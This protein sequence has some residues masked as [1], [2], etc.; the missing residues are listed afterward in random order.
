MQRRSRVRVT[1]IRSILL[2]MA[3][4]LGVLGGLFVTYLR[5]LPTLEALEEY[6]PSLVTTLY[7]DH[8]EPFATLFEQKR[9]WIPLDTIPRHLINGVIAVEDAQFYQHRGINFRGIA[10]ALL[11]NLRALRPAEGGSSITQQ[12]AKLLLLTPEKHLSRKIKEAVLAIE[13]EKRYSKEKILELYLNQVYFGHGAYGVESAAHTY[14]K[15]PV[16]QLNLAEAA[17]L[18]GLPRAPN[19]Y[20]PIADKE[21][22]IRRRNHV[23]TRM[24]EEGFI[25]KQQAASALAVTFNEFPFEKTRNLGPYFVEYIRQ[26]LEERYGTYAVYHGGLKVYTTL[27]VGAQRSAETAL[28][29]GLREIDKARGFRAPR[30]RSSSAAVTRKGALSYLIPKAGE[31]LSATVTKILPKAVTVQV[32]G[33]QGDIALDKVPWLDSSQPRQQLQPGM[34]LKVQVLR[35]NTRT[36]MLDLSLEQDPEI[37]GA[38]LAIDPGDG[39][40]KAMIGGYDF[41][42]SKFNRAV[43]ARRQPGSAFKPFVYAAAF[44]RGLTPSTI[45][46]DAPVS[47]PILADGKR[48]E[49]SPDNYDRKFRGPTTLRYGLEHSINVVAVKLIE[50]IGVDSVIELARNL[51]IESTLRREYA[52]ALGVSEVTLSELVSAFGVFAHS[53]IRFLPYGIRKVTDNKGA[54]LEEYI[55]VGQQT[56][57]E[58]TAFT[59]TSVL[60]GV[61]ERGTG[62][63][64]RV[65]GR[66]VAGK[67]GTTQAATDAWFIGYTPHLVAGVWVGY[68]TKRSLGPH[69]SAATLA[70]PIWTRF[71]QRAV[72]DTPTEEFPVPANAAPALVN[73]VSGRPT[74]SDDKDAIK[75]FVF[76]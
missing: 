42:R 58:E 44:D 20:S 76:R 17:T 11:V 23:L 62:S 8:D 21:R 70:V 41:E 27:N 9:F 73:Y 26:Q 16:D 40:I 28:L 46:N 43:Q 69:E 72:Q 61:V 50:R 60:A 68:D 56:M 5:D 30:I 52:L 32:G 63:R 57:R 36:K 10:R 45:I 71:M 6:Q 3:I 4:S 15:K 34:E 48:I 31:T 64:A 19:Y 14:F 59:V 51:G 54:L 22:A 65:L 49:W 33:Y 39:G 74:T 25:T 75:E 24:A 29:E 12:L 13:I 2:L 1:A 53:G 38:F 7:S 67:T 35:V 37:E 18:A 66:P 55:P 47:Y